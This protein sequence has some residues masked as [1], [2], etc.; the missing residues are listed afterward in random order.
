MH[1][2][3][4]L[5]VAIAAPA[6]WALYQAT[7][8]TAAA[9]DYTKPVPEAAGLTAY[10]KDGSIQV[11]LD[12]LPLLAYRAQASL[13]YPYFSPLNG[14]VSGLSLIAESAEPYPHHRGLWLGCDPVNGGNY[15]ADNGL[16]SGQIRSLELQLAA[17]TAAP[18]TTTPGSPT[19]A[20]PTPGSVVFTEK[21]VWTRSGSSP[22]HDQRRYAISVPDK[23]RVLI[24]CRFVIT[25]D[26]IVSI[27]SAKHSFFA[28]RAAADISPTY[29]GTLMNSAGG[30]GAE[31]TYGKS[32]NWCAYFG[33]RRQRPDVVEGIAILN[34]PKNFGGN[35][36]WF[37]RDYGHL[38]PS[39]FAF[40]DQPWTLAKGDSLELNYRVVLFAGTPQQAELD[41]IY[42]QWAA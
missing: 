8:H 33:Q 19:P 16:E 42:H 15:W 22:L 18:G 38:S 6:A 41:S 25:A 13:K 2:R 30:T 20:S 3:Q 28:L 12:N 26:E 1:R 31:G 9:V 37:T 21:C 24:D 14:P 17:K 34:H 5:K 27:K 7:P 40:L 11:R 39:P 23:Q 29:G 4:L 35:C 32:A 10:Q 36:P